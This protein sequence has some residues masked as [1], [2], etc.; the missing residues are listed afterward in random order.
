MGALSPLPRRRA[1]FY[2]GKEVGIDDGFSC[3]NHWTPRSTGT[4]NVTSSRDRTAAH[5]L[6]LTD[7]RTPRR[8]TW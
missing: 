6:R 7:D 3:L 5:G 4:R 8:S 2:D 1:K